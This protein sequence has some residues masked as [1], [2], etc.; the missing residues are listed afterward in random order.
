MFPALNSPR[1]VPIKPEFSAVIVL[2]TKFRRLR[3]RPL[4]GV[5]KSHRP[6]RK[7]GRPTIRGLPRS[8]TGAI[9]RATEAAF[10]RFAALA[11]APLTPLRWLGFVQPV[12]EK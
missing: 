4:T 10:V 6:L 7:K 2:R 11:T 12:E 1:E 5:S 9:P 8:S 3:K